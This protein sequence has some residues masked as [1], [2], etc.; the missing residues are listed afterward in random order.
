MTIQRAIRFVVYVMSSILRLL[1]W[2][3]QYYA[4][5]SFERTEPTCGFNIP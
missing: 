4:T 5:S 2:I 1:Y 3:L